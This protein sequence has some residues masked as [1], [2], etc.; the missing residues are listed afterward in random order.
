M[1]MR[2]FRS[3]LNCLYFKTIDYNFKF[4]PHV[5]IHVYEFDISVFFLVHLYFSM[6]SSTI[7]GKFIT[8]IFLLVNILPKNQIICSSDLTEQSSEKFI[9]KIFQIME[10]FIQQKN[11][12]FSYY[13]QN[14]YYVI[15]VII[16][17][18]F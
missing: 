6:R 14:Y 11:F 10:K 2:T 18:L 12:D 15:L 8:F 16:I 17:L 13:S 4:I 9:L 1:L 3:C 5:V 7:Y